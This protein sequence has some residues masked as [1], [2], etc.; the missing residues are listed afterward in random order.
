MASGIILPVLTSIVSSASEAIII[1]SQTASKQALAKAISQA[2]LSPGTP[3]KQSVGNAIAPQ[4][5]RW[6]PPQYGQP[7]IT[8]IS[9]TYPPFTV[10]AKQASP[11]Q[12]DYVFDA[13]F[14]IIHRKVLRKT[15]HPVLT[16]ASIS[17]H[18]YVEASRVTLEI[19]MSDAMASYTD[20]MWTG[21]A[22]KSVSAW[23]KIKEFQ[24]NKMV[25][26]LTTRLD[27][28]S[29][30]M[31]IEA[32]SN[33]DRST[34][35]G[36]KAT[37]VLEELLSASVISVLDASARPPATNT[38]SGGVIQSSPVDPN[39]AADHRIP[40]FLQRTN[41]LPTSPMPDFPVH[42]PP[43]L[44]PPS[45][46]PDLPITFPPSMPDIPIDNLLKYSNKLPVNF[47]PQVPGAGV[48]SGN[49]LEE[50]LK[51]GATP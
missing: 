5:A 41:S 11:V 26:T 37:I 48:V 3:L 32:E 33:D 43:N 36:L 25:L 51:P 1:G 28:Y 31:V 9:A 21:T 49:R 34:K 22:G 19:G 12:I 7:A 40:E 38:T 39:N 16:G 6:V 23:Q 29:K 10:S 44:L 4:S 20:T 15:Q 2:P 50:I 45:A 18:A 35:H 24:N 27:V 42:F 14:K 13:V 30:M 17:D 47:Y 46:P 8:M